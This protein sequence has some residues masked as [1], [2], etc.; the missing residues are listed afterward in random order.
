MAPHLSRRSVARSAGPRAAPPAPVQAAALARN[1]AQTLVSARPR[2]FVCRLAAA[3]V[4]PVSSRG[5][6]AGCAREAGRDPL[7]RAPGLPWHRCCLPVARPTGRLPP[8][9]GEA[10]R[11]P[12][13]GGLAP[14]W[15]RG[16]SGKLARRGTS[17]GAAGGRPVPAG[18]ARRPLGASDP[19]PCSRLERARRLSGDPGRLREGGERARERRGDPPYGAASTFGAPCLPRGIAGASPR[20]AGALRAGPERRGWSPPGGPRSRPAPRTVAGAAPEVDRA[21]RPLCGRGRDF[22][23]AAFA[24]P[25][26]GSPSGEVGGAAFLRASSSSRRPSPLRQ[27]RG[28]V[29]LKRPGSPRFRF[30]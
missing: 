29:G 5:A 3:Q 17:S 10:P 20:P 24:P 11:F 18:R 14:A 21:A 13:A 4:C 7:S 22:G 30:V 9:S 27:M 23:A 19:A 26:E 15:P 16:R 1:R 8:H 2:S 28:A 6:T 25:Q 12:P